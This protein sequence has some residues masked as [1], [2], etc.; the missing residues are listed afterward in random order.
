M[1]RIKR[2]VH[3]SLFKPLAAVLDQLLT[4]KVKNRPQN[5]KGVAYSGKEGHLSEIRTL[6]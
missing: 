5:G 1:P 6:T 2:P 3:W 4:I